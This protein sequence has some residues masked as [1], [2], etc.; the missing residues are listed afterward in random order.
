MLVRT[1]HNGVFPGTR[2]R[3]PQ[4]PHLRCGRETMGRRRATVLLVIWMQ[5]QSVMSCGGVSV[6]LSSAAALK[7]Q[8]TGVRVEC[9][10]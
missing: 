8:A 10:P 2:L 7:T 6:E 4:Q 1:Q 3:R 5:M 9:Q